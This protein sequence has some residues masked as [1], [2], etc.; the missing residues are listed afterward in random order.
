MSAPYPSFSEKAAA[1]QLL[2]RIRAQRLGR[3]WSQLEMAQRAGVS[4]AAYK[5]FE[6]GVGNITLINLLKILSVL[7]CLDRLAEL[8]PPVVP[9][10]K[11][12]LATLEKPKRVR[13]TARRS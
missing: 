12:T 10:E 2:D 1:A 6:R 4:Y 7:N 5:A 3:N 9:A 8:V 13:A 11:E